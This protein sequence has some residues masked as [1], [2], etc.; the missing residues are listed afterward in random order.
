MSCQSCQL[1]W[2]SCR[3]PVHIDHQYWRKGRHAGVRQWPLSALS[4][5]HY[6]PSFHPRQSSVFFAMLKAEKAWAWQ[7]PQT[8]CWEDCF[9]AAA[10]WRLPGILSLPGITL[11]VP[12]P[13]NNFCYAGRI[14]ALVS[15]VLVQCLSS[16]FTSITSTEQRGH[17]HMQ[18]SASHH[19]ERTILSSVSMFANGQNDEECLFRNES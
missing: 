11:P 3:N 6:L 7:T 19:Y 2:R 17:A 8:L 9:V 16:Q 14:W 10:L 18:V 12:V 15:L 5:N 4:E 13:L 1:T